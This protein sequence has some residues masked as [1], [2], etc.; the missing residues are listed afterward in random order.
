MEKD[1]GICRRK[2]DNGGL[3]GFTLIELIG[4]IAIISILAAVIL[5]NVFGQIRKSRVARHMAQADDISKGAAAYFADMAIWPRLNQFDGAIKQLL[6]NPGNVTPVLWRGPYIDK[7]PRV[8]GT[9]RFVSLYH[10]CLMLNSTTF[11][12][13]QAS[14]TDRN[15]NGVA[16]D[17]YVY[18]GDIPAVEAQRV[19]Q[20]VDGQVGIAT[21]AVVQIIIGAD[22]CS[23]VADGSNW[24]TDAANTPEAMAIIYSE[25]T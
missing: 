1:L 19:D 20:I 25:G 4:A 24:G 17:R 6:N 10:G 18:F 9:P 13:G 7:A 21:G 3:A 23:V 11:G 14:E 22:N 8:N 5:P 12:F 16:F 2:R 15:G